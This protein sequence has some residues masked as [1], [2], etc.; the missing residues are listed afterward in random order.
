MK[1]EIHINNFNVFADNKLILNNINLNIEARKI[2]CII[3]PSG[4]GKSTLIRSINR[5]NDDYRDFK[6]NGDIVFQGKSIYDR[7]VDKADLRAKIGMVFQ[8]PCVFPGSIKENVLFGIKQQKKLT[9]SEQQNIAEE[10]LR[11]VSL[12]NEVK[13]RLNMKASLLSIGQQQR[14]CI[15]RTISMKPQVILLDEPTSSLDPLSTKA[16]EQ[17]MLNLK[18]DY[19]IV[20][21][22]HN[23]NQAKRIADNLIFISNGQLIEYGETSQILMEPKDERTKL[24]LSEEIGK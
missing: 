21:V 19:T 1:T 11:T 16:I 5:I 4:G 13:D 20:F 8:K 9:K 15:A 10:S 2:S 18:L 22:T 7:Y 23:I 6:L 17:M 14:L 24:Y 3:G 12:W